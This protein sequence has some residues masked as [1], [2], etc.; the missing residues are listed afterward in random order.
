ML[1][2]ITA[3]RSTGATSSTAPTP[4]P[5]PTE[6]KD[7]YKGMSKNELAVNLQ[8]CGQAITGEVTNL[9]SW[10]Q[11][12]AAKGTSEHYKLTMIQKYIMANAF[13]DDADVPLTSPLLNMIMK[14]AWTE[15]DGN[16]TRPSLL[17]AMEG[18]SPFR[19]LNPN[20]D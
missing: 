19:M 9:P 7:D 4:A 10:I 14:R 1:D 3:T 2:I 16:V 17:H 20:V 15:K 13:Y 11:Y 18:L 8:I 12:C 6:E 5:T